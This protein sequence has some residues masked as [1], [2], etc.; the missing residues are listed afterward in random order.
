M[1]RIRWTA[2]A[3]RDFIRIADDYARVAPEFPLRLLKRIDALAELLAGEPG[4]GPELKGRKDRKFRIKGSDYILIH[5]ASRSELGI[6][7]VQHGRKN[8]RRAP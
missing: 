8:W 3:R 7:R 5:R 6:L 2:Q 1:R 4:I